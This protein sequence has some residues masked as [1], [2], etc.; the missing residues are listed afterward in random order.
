MSTTATPAFSSSAAGAGG[1]RRQANIAANKARQTISSPQGARRN[2]DYIKKAR[3]RTRVNAPA[4]LLSGRRLRSF[5]QR[6]QFP[7]SEVDFRELRLQLQPA[8]R[9]IDVE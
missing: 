6:P 1:A 3:R 5:A 8:F 2:V 4:L 9:R 7:A